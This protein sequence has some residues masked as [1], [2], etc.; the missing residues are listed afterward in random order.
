MEVVGGLCCREMGDVKM[1]MNSSIAG[2]GG[3]LPAVAQLP[4]FILFDINS[5]GSKA[6]LALAQEIMTK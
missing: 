2:R 6:Y 5:V 3:W 4:D 1:G